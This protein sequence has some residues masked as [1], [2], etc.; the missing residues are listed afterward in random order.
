MLKR[1][2]KK[3]FNV[4]IGAFCGLLAGA[5]ISL[6]FAAIGWVGMSVFKGEIAPFEEYRKAAGLSFVM[7]GSIC[8]F[9]GGIFGGLYHE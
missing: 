6:V 1:I 9:A 2:V 3:I 4:I 5:I 7:M 8:A